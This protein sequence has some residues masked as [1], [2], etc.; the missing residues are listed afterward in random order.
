MKYFDRYW[1]NF[2]LIPGTKTFT[3][4]ANGTAEVRG[5]EF[6]KAYVAALNA[7]QRLKMYLI[8]GQKMP[9]RFAAALLRS[10]RTRR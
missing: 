1:G 3:D 4:Q 9:R 5:E 7:R 10:R 8:K 6:N 2:R